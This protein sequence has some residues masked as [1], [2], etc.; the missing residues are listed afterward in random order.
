MPARRTVPFLALLVAVTVSLGGGAGADE[1]ADL[2]RR[3]DDLVF[4]LRVEQAIARGATWLAARQ[5]DDGSFA[6]ADPFGSRHEFGESA[7]AT[8]TLAHCGYPADHE[9]ME[10]AVSYLR[11]SYRTCLGGDFMR[12]G[13]SYS[14]SVFVLALHALFAKEPEAHA[15][16]ADARYGSGQAARQNPCG[17]PAWAR[18]AIDES[19]DFLLEH[20]TE[21]GLYRYPG[22]GADEDLSNSQYVLLALYAG[23][24]CGYEVPAEALE[25]MARRL[26][27]WQERTGPPVVR[28]PDPSPEEEARAGRY[29]PPAHGTKA[30]DRARG[31]GYVPG[32][33]PTGSMTAAGLSSVVTAKAMLLELGP[34]AA[35]LGD[36]LDQAAWDA[37]AWLDQEFTVKE[38]PPFGPTWHY[39]YLYG[40]ERALVIAG[41]R[42]VGERDWYRLG[43][44]HLLDAQHTADGDPDR[45]AWTP[46]GG[47]RGAVT[48][49]LDTC[50]AL[51]FLKRAAVGRDR[52][53]LP[54]PVVTPR[55]PP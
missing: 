24:R 15:G 45:G 52:P 32:H 28:R 10:R 43:A 35:G 3:K 54:P 9:V 17:Y 53:V 55:D 1:A 40:L 34:A 29:A 7:L 11:R 5:Q 39:Y 20:Q 42:T 4:R 26:L 37:I 13:S 47:H 2:E 25:R 50:F 27:L 30:P 49:L 31:F 36:A 6:A 8:L 12:Q 18:K 33:R 22:P 23:T 51:L 14:L 44:D 48:P 46:P 21:A 16:G 38:N 41:K 19:L